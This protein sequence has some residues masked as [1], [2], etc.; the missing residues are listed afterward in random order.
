MNPSTSVP[1]EPDPALGEKSEEF[2]KS[3]NNNFKV[4]T[5]LKEY[6]ATSGFFR[7]FRKKKKG[8]DEMKS[9]LSEDELINEKI[10]IEE[11][12]KIYEVCFFSD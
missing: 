11:L 12:R 1:L 4:F 9:P 10:R 3:N 8:K 2:D 6:F 5:F 7:F